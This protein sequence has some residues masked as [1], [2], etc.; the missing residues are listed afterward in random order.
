MKIA[1]SM[2]D[3]IGLKTVPFFHVT[4]LLLNAALIAKTLASHC[5][6]GVSWI[7]QSCIFKSFYF[8]PSDS[9][10][11]L[12]L[13]SST[14]IIHFSSNRIPEGLKCLLYLDRRG[15][16]PLLSL[17]LTDVFYICFES[18]H[19]KFHGESHFDSICRH[20]MEGKRIEQYTWLTFKEALIEGTIVEL[21]ISVACDTR[22]APIS[23]SNKFLMLLFDVWY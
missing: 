9:D 23:A 20:A 16:S 18:F 12:S 10:F 2:S 5:R 17:Q 3:E 15:K 7:M 14:V 8:Y 13:S 4:C 21:H 1:A 11:S 22:W 6:N 19:R